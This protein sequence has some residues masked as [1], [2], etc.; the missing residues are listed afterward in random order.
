MPSI[1]L[2]T[3]ILVWWRVN[4]ERLSKPQANLL[5]EMEKRREPAAISAITLREIAWMVACGRLEIAISLDAWMEEIEANPFLAIIPITPKV[6]AESVR[7]GA[8]FP[9]DPADQIIVA[10]ARC[11]GLRLMTADG[12]IRRWGKVP[13]I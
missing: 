1:L 11:H 9:R 3:H 13:L 7:L 8:D 5:L 6:A 4:P 10:T 12:H 2:D